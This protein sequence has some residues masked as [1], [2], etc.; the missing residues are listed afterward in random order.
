MQN[1]IE[2]RLFILKI[3][4]K[5]A[6]WTWI[7]GHNYVVSEWNYPTCNSIPLLSDTNVYAMHMQNFTEICLFILNPSHAVRDLCR[8]RQYPPWLLF[9]DFVNSW[10]TQ[11]TTAEDTQ[12]MTHVRSTI[13]LVVRVISQSKNNFNDVIRLKIIESR[14][15]PKE[16][17]KV[18]LEKIKQ[19]GRQLKATKC[20]WISSA[21]ISNLDVDRDFS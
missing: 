15:F 3:L 10:G 12:T 17:V 16:T 21:E 9:T 11:A 1:F 20:R 4:S 6:F 2:I 8:V 18:G 5:N 19:N 13:S 14:Y 7:K